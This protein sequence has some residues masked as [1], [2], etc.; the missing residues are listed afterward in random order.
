[1]TVTRHVWGFIEGHDLHLMRKVN[2]WRPP[3][4]IR[5][6]MIM[7]TRAG[8][9]WLWYALGIFL[10]LAGGPQRFTAVG[11][12]G[13]ASLAGILLFKWLK[14][15]SR[16][17]RPCQIEPHCWSRVLPPDQFSFPSDHT[18]TAFSIAVVLSLFY[19]Q[20]E[21]VL[22]FTACSIALSRIVLGMHF[23]SDVVAG[24]GLGTVLGYGAITGC[25][26]I[27]LI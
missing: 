27:G 26:A 4:W 23:L 1:M 21:G 12:P 5:Y 11:A 16:R 10:L 19:P 22:F 6:W 18:M 14:G 9:G 8:D 15:L 13:A 3:R 24:V 2:R 20:L 25:A 7:A 17:P